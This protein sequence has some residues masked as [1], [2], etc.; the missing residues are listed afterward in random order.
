MSEGRTIY[1]AAVDIGTTHIRVSL[2][3]MERGLRLARRSGLN[4]QSIFGPDVLTRLKAASESIEHAAELSRMARNAVGEA[5]SDISLRD[6]IDLLK[7][8]QVIVVGNTAMLSLLTGNNYGL[9]LQPD[10]WRR[11]IDCR[12]KD[13]KPW[14]VSWGLDAAA[15]VEV[16]QPI[17]GFVGSDLLAGILATR[18]TEGQPGSLLIDFG[19]NS[20]IALWDGRKL[21]VTSAAGGPAFEGSG[22]SCG[23]PAE[24]GAIFRTEYIKS[25]GS[26]LFEVIGGGEPRGICGS[27]MVDA[28][29]CMVRA[30]I[31]KSNGNFTGNMGT[32]TMFSQGDALRNRNN[33]V[34][35]PMFIKKQ[36]IDVFQR[37]KAAIGAGIK[38]LLKRAGMSVNSLN[39]IC[40]C[41][42]FGRYLNMPNAQDIGLLP[43]ISPKAIELCGDTALAGCELLL[44]DRDR[45]NTLEALRKKAS[46]I[47]LAQGPAFENCFIENL[48]LRPI[49]V[50]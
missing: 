4:S 24:P 25:S 50:D 10:Y 1:G 23:M 5:L 33:M 16:V 48:Y 41:G 45:T 44:L 37:A 22:I 2:L 43:S 14:C 7:I 13:T 40:V 3:D 35:V 28:I 18:L 6:G 47:N 8:G 9:L 27:G 26:Y 32:T 49:Q 17:A 46:I 21:W 20:E 39:R 19:T 42:A 31:L 34:V 30:G 38:C 11:R 12:I 36:D 29:A 15:S